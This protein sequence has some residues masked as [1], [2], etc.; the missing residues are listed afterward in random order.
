MVELLLLT[1]SERLSEANHPLDFE[2]LS[3]YSKQRSKTMK[4]GVVLRLEAA[5]GK[6]DMRSY[7]TNPV[8]EVFFRVDSAC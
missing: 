6:S 5:R 2:D 7:Y 8:M 4:E 1:V 3:S